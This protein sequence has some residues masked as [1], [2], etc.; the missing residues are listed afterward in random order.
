MHMLPLSYLTFIASAPGLVCR[1]S[2]T[3]VHLLTSFGVDQGE[4]KKEDRRESGIPAEQC[5]SLAS[6]LGLS[7]PETRPAFLNLGR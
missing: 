5:V 3:D 4:S 1:C 2:L 7:I 6:D